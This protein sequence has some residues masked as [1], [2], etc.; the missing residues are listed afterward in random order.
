MKWEL[1]YSQQVIIYLV[2]LREAGEEIRRAIRSL[3]DTEDG[4]PSN[5]ITQ[6]EP[7]IYLWEVADHLV[8]YHRQQ[9]KSRIRI[10]VVESIE[11]S[12]P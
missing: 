9:E 7:N 5:G 11:S 4:I 10:V 3:Q 2:A 8:V 6:P 1:H 12:Y